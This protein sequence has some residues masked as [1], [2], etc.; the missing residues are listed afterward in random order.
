MKRIDMVGRIARNSL[1]CFAL[2]NAALLVGILV[3]H[4]GA[5]FAFSLCVICPILGGVLSTLAEG[6]KAEKEKKK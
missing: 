1:I 6:V 2:I 4:S 5:R 3:L